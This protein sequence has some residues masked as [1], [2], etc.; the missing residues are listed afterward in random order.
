M[1]AGK[2]QVVDEMVS[3][4]LTCK[5]MGWTYQEYMDQPIHFLQTVEALRMAEAEESERQKSY[6][7]S[8]K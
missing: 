5:Y 3:V 8:Q 2:K 7:D 1:V 4:V 6:D